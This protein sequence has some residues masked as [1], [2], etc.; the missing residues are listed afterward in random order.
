MA[1]LQDDL[2]CLVRTTVCSVWN[3]LRYFGRQTSRFVVYE[4]NVWMCVVAGPEKLPS[5]LPFTSSYMPLLS[6]L[7]T[8]LE[9]GN[10]KG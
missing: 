5:I 2:L 8:E 7:P 1:D 6:K 10:I 3:R 9:L 4:N